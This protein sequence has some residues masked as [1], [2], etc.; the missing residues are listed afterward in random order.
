MQVRHRVAEDVVVH[1]HRPE[2][3][4]NRGAYDQQLPPGEFSI[5]TITGRVIKVDEAALSPFEV[6]EEQAKAWL[7]DEFGK[8]L[9]GARA[10]VDRFVAKLRGEPH[11]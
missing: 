2:H 3:A 7:K 1:L 8:M 9:D 5:T 6:T 10:A 11:V 4:L